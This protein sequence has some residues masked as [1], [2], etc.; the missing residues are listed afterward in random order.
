L[1][2][3]LL[4]LWDAEEKAAGILKTAQLLAENGAID[5]QA[6]AKEKC[7]KILKEYPNTKAAEEA[8]KLLDKWKK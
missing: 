7:Q 2:P 3:R 4:Q 8:K 5:G 1:K 6:G